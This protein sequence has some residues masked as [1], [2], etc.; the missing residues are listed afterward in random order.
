V[1]HPN[2]REDF[3]RFTL[4]ALKALVAGQVHLDFRDQQGYTAVH[5]AAQTGNLQVL[6]VYYCNDKSE[7]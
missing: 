6:E 3:D 1:N 5:V 7:H 2:S 4:P